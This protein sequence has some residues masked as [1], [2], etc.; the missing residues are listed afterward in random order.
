MYNAICQFNPLSLPL[1]GVVAVDVLPV[2]NS[3]AQ[4]FAIPHVLLAN[5]GYQDIEAIRQKRRSLDEE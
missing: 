2:G 4:E 5:N 3:I 1:S